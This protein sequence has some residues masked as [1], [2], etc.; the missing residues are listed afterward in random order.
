MRELLLLLLLLLIVFILMITTTT[1]TTPTTTTKR[2]KKT[3]KQQQQQQQQQQQRLESALAKLG[4]GGAINE[5][6]RS[7]QW[8]EGEATTQLSKKHSIA[9]EP[10]P[11]PVLPSARRRPS[12]QLPPGVEAWDNRAGLQRPKG[13]G[14][15]GS[16]S[17]SS[18][19]RSASSSIASSRRDSKA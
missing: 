17:A 2:N 10:K 11:E 7:P 9:N 19:S 5:E 15:C 14:V 8:P 12:K 4:A 1:P 18:V 6:P 3:K 13:E 16:G